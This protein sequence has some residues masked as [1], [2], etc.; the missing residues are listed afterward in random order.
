M[1]RAVFI[2]AGLHGAIHMHRL[3]RR[4]N[5]KGVLQD[6]PAMMAIGLPAILANL[7]TSVANGFTLHIF[8]AF[9]NPW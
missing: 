6:V 9:G 7:A 5:R 4:P 3:V 2:S 1:S 8:A